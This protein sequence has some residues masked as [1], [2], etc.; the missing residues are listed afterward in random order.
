M[1]GYLGHSQLARVAATDGLSFGPW[2]S[3]EAE[4]WTSRSASRILGQSAETP[5]DVGRIVAPHPFAVVWGLTLR[6]R[7]L[8]GA[9]QHAHYSDIGSLGSSRAALAVRGRSASST[10]GP[11]R[12]QSRRAQG[13]P[14]YAAWRRTTSGQQGWPPPNA[15]GSGRDA[16]S[17]P[18]SAWIAA[19]RPL[20]LAVRFTPLG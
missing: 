13:L 15:D 8:T 14:A 1:Q 3:E 4:R 9:P 10:P 18:S 16:Y 11:L 5:D 7:R 17:R 19:G 12:G 20:A 6:R 2:G